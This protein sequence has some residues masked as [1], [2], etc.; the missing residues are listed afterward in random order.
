MASP[1][2]LLISGVPL[3]M[4]PGFLPSKKMSLLIMSIKRIPVFIIVFRL[5]RD[6]TGF[7]SITL[8]LSAGN[9]KPLLTKALAASYK[10]Q[11]DNNHF[12][13]CVE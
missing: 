13:F 6:G 9:R 2:V 7:D 4:K 12:L 11:S 1:V 8:R 10:N 5:K 3:S